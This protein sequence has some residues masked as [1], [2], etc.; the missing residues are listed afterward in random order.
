M[1]TAPS[2]AGRALE[3][4]WIAETLAWTWLGVAGAVIE[5]LTGSHQPIASYPQPSPAIPASV[6]LR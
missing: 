2:T 5:N 4:G 3:R 6:T 1:F